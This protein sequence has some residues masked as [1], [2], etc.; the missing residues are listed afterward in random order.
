MQGFGGNPEGRRQ[1][2]RC[3][4]RWEHNIEIGVT[5]VGCWGVD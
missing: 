3:R 4:H 2:G 1:L 5:E